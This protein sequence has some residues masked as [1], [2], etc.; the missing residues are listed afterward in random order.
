[1]M[2]D[3][4]A[5]AN[6]FLMQFQADLLGVELERPAVLET[7]AL[8]AAAMAGTSCGFWE[9]REA[10][11]EHR[12]VDRVFQPKMSDSVRDRLYAEWKAAVRRTLS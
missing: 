9:S 3:G 12:T 11:L 1:M 2:V 4:G 8:G 7:T 5:S 10:F 6:D